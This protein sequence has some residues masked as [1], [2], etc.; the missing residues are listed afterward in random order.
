MLLPAF[1]AK[2]P[3]QRLVEISICFSSSYGVLLKSPLNESKLNKSAKYQLHNLSKEC[4]V[5]S[6]CLGKCRKPLSKPKWFCIP[7]PLIKIIN[8]YKTLSHLLFS[9]QICHSKRCQTTPI[10]EICW[11]KKQQAVTESMHWI[12]AKNVLVAAEFP[13]WVQI[14]WGFP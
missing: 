4:D 13:A 14:L 1:R 2:R 11:S 12:V 6:L 8:G 3:F 9:T 5:A 7:H 10:S